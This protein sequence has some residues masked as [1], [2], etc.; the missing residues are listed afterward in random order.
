[1]SFELS[2][3]AQEKLAARKQHYVKSLGAKQSEIESLAAPVFAGDL[4][5][6]ALD[7]LREV[8][9]KIAGSAG[10]YG[11][12][13]LQSV[14]AKLDVALLNVASIEPPVANNLADMVTEVLAAFGQARQGAGA[15]PPEVVKSSAAD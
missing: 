10:M 5:A 4:S 3:A 1:M 12:A 7:P 2:A 11:F 15:T 14:A 8:V 6:S 9:H 13:E